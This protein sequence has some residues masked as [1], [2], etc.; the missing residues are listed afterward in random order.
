M[1]YDE[2]ESI[3]M[4]NTIGKSKGHELYTKFYLSLMEKSHAN[5]YRM[6]ITGKCEKTGW[7]I[8]ISM[9][10]MKNPTRKMALYFFLQEETCYNAHSQSDE[11]L[12]L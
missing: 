3:V 11:P 5:G 12:A 10:M 2:F 7:P 8:D 9:S 6:H 1:I 4:R